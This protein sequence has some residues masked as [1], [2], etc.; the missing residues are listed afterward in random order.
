M[1]KYTNRN[2]KDYK[3][4]LSVYHLEGEDTSS[5]LPTPSIPIPRQASFISILDIPSTPPPEPEAPVLY[6][7]PVLCSNCRN[8]METT[9]QGHFLDQSQFQEDQQS[10]ES[11]PYIDQAKVNRQIVTDLLASSKYTINIEE[12]LAKI[13]KSRSIKQE[14]TIAIVLALLGCA[15]MMPVKNSNDSEKNTEHVESVIQDKE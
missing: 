13:V 3:H 15:S 14:D 6:S 4:F 1:E 8:P 10:Q 9:Q 7:A 11:H 5:E 12:L 2:G